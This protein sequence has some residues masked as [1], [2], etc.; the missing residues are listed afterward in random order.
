[1]D[2]EPVALVL[3]DIDLVRALQLARI[4]CA[5]FAPPGDPVLFSRFARPAGDWIDAWKEPEELVTR[6]L[7]F[8]AA[9]PRPPVLFYQEDGT[10]LLV[11]RERD[12]LAPA[13]RFV[14]PAA[15]LAEDLVNKAR[16]QSLAERLH[17]PVP[18]ARVLHP[19]R[20]EQAP[21]L[22]LTFPIVVKPLT[23]RSETWGSIG[24]AAKALQAD[25]PE[26]FR[27]L[28]PRLARAGTDFIA[29]VLVPGPASCVVSYHVY[30]DDR[31]EIAAEFTGRKIRTHPAEH[32][33]STALEITDA[34]DVADAGRELTRRLGLV[35]VAKF[36][37]KRGPDGT[38]HLLE[39]NPRFTLWHHPAARAGV[40]VPAMVYADLVGRP[41]PRP[42][43]VRV[44]VRWCKPWGDLPAARA[45][46]IGT[47]RWLAWALRCEAKRALAADDPLL[48]PR[49]LWW[50]ARRRL[51]GWVRRV[52]ARSAEPGPVPGATDGA[53]PLR[54]LM[55]TTEWPRERW[56]GTATFIAR[57]AHFLRAA[58]V[59]VDVVEFRGAKNP[60]RYGW[61]WLRVHRLLWRGRYDLVHAQFGQ[62]ALAVLPTG[63]PFV[64][65]LRGDDLEGIISDR[66]GRFTVWGRALQGFSRFAARRADA[67]I[68]VSAHMKQLLGARAP[69]HVIPSGIDFERFRCIPR[70]EARRR[71]GLPLAER[72]VLFVGR[73]TVL[74]KRYAL[75]QDAVALLNQRLPARLVLGWGVPH[76][77]IPYYMN[78]C[79][80]LICTSSQEGS[81]NAVKEA[82]ACNLPVV[83]VPVGD[84]P[85][86]LRGVANCELCPDDRPETL[87][88]ALER[89]LRKGERS[90]GRRVVAELDERVLTRQ[91]IGVYRRAVQAR[92]GA[93]GAAAVARVESE[94]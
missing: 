51:A 10:L 43:P 53:R 21:D 27:S 12:R 71:L 92:T 23:R 62:S 19:D 34:P 13:F 57:Q 86:R 58:G 47:M 64:V 72:L 78:A 5:A 66:S 88:A 26:A 83:S 77:V 50:H 2:V 41:R 44:G 20:G 59:E 94:G 79:D 40:N 68:I 87:A 39:V 3:G 84:V 46:G 11:S 67:V 29:Q 22:D 42:R 17:L 82:L 36:D 1:M 35:G 69:T 74:R 70:D 56:G 85:E 28:W 49:L 52:L 81:P 54:V 9:Q 7:G 4:P 38:L 65:T 80:A 93:A 73:P 90:D 15:E 89:V 63:L 16:F 31:G 61:A 60:L 25:T 6:L 91:V 14:V 30:V 37:F 18:A 48:P 55:V 32:G 24:T 33:R 76:E 8:A 45:A 75:A